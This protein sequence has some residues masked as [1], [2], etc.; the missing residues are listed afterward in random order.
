M[1]NVTKTLHWE[2]VGWMDGLNIT[3]L[4]QEIVSGHNPLWQS[5]SKQT[6]FCFVIAEC[7]S[8]CMHFPFHKTC[9]NDVK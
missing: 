7:T 9:D 2:E 8:V 3:S 5:L 4:G 1:T 6:N